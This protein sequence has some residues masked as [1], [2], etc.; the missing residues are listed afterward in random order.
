[1]K[2]LAATMILVLGLAACQQEDPTNIAIDEG[3]SLNADIETLPPD[4]SSLN[5]VAGGGLNA[6][7]DAGSE[8]PSPPDTPE[9]RMIPGQYRGRWGMVAADCDQSRSDAKGAITIGERSIIFYESRAILKEQRP[10]IATSFS[11]LF[12]FTGEGQSWEKVMTFTRTGNT[13]K[14]AEESGTFTYTRCA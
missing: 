6:A 10:A 14:R 7:D 8:L 12:A 1:M 11:G 13:L 5:N 9:A 4:E 2:R 3:N